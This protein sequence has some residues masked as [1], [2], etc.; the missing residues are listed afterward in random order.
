[1]YFL[2]LQAF[3]AIVQT[4]NLSKAAE[5]LYLTP[6]T[7]SYRLKTLEQ[8][9]GVELV[10]RRKGTAH[11]R[12]TPSGEN[13][14]KL[15]ERWNTLWQE[16]QMF[17]NDGAQLSLNIS[18]PNS[19]NMYVL[20]PLYRALYQHVPRIRF[21]VHTEHTE[22]SVGSVVR[23]DMDIAFL[24]R[25][26][27]IP[28]TVLLEPFIEEEMVLLRLAT[29]ERESMVCVDM[30]SLDPEHE[31][32]WR[33]GAAYQRWHDQH[34][35]PA[36]P[37]RVR[38]DMADLIP[39]LMIDPKQWAIAVNSVAQLFAQSGRFVIQKLSDP[40]Q[41]RICYKL[42]HKYPAPSTVQ[43]LAILDHYLQELFKGRKTT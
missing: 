41:N 9:M 7:I 43:S 18:A 29:P 24:V 33:W 27:P 22:E 38:V 8:D 13:F 6:S 3:L 12:L 40:P 37:R 20:P 31:L 28:A 36:F 39:A 30:D 17:K 34:W 23:R 5:L 25:E 32:Y 2:G 42:L 19:L 35:D 11:V 1:M 26:V 4:K 15:A 14:T 16:T 10:E 21:W